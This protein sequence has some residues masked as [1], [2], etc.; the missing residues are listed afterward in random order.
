[1][2]LLQRIR[3]HID[4][5]R[6]DGTEHLD[7]SF[8]KLRVWLS[9]LPD[10]SA[11]LDPN[12]NSKRPALR[13]I[14]LSGH[15]LESLPREI[16]RL[17]GLTYLNICRNPIRQLPNVPLPPLII[18][19]LQWQRLGDQLEDRTI[20]GLQILREDMRSDIDF[21][22]EIE[23]RGILWL[24]LIG[25]LQDRIPDSLWRLEQLTHLDLRYNRLSKLP[26][27]IGQLHRLTHL[28][29]RYNFISELP[30][31][32]GQLQQLTSLDLRYNQ[33]SNLPESVGQL[34]QLTRFDLRYN[35]FSELPESI[36]QLRR[37]TRFDLGGNQLSGLPESIGQLQRL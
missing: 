33:L 12:G 17:A 1:M 19:T 31:S 36:G 5:A 13:S 30:E 32:I 27:S 10:L 21:F 14:D 37:L 22:S 6:A 8:N 20:F 3:Q 11:A 24:S 34:R 29:L 18:D 15:S 25:A 26:E 16:K 28:D 23:Q 4:Q 2:D 7:L 9:A 35:R